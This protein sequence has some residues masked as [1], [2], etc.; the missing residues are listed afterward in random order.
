MINRQPQQQHTHTEREKNDDTG[1]STSDSIIKM[2][3]EEHKHINLLMF[4]NND[5]NSITR[6]ITTECKNGRERERVAHAQKKK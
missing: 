1:T 4:T 5:Y 2:V 3:T 6:P